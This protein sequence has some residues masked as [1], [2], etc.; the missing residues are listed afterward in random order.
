MIS[1]LNTF[2]QLGMRDAY[3]FW[4]QET[5][6]EPG[7]M[8]DD[9]WRETLQAL[10]KSFLVQQTSI[11]TVV[12]ENADRAALVLRAS[13]ELADK[14]SF[15][16]GLAAEVT[17]GIVED[18]LPIGSSFEGHPTRLAYAIQDNLVGVVGNMRDL[19]RELLTKTTVAGEVEGRPKT[20]L[21][22]TEEHWLLHLVVDIA[23]ANDDVN[24]AVFRHLADHADHPPTY[25]N[26]PSGGYAI[27]RPLT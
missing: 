6:V 11:G 13:A 27:Y 12:A 10:T 4:C 8:N 14:L 17:A 20:V 16:P 7:H 19:L 2:P 21:D 26:L 22:L 5:G 25:V 18:C 1:T 9:R 24:T 3:D 23:L 15:T